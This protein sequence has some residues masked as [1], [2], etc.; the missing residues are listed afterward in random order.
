M[1]KQ[2]LNEGDRCSTY[3]IMDGDGVAKGVGGCAFWKASV[4]GVNLEPISH[5]TRG[6]RASVVPW[7]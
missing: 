7:E 3:E 5:L 4:P 6:D 2:P 1:S